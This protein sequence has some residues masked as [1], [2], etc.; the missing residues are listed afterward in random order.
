MVD[1]AQKLKI[2]NEYTRDRPYS[3]NKEI[4]KFTNIYIP[5]VILIEKGIRCNNWKDARDDFETRIPYMSLRNELGTLKRLRAVK[6]PEKLAIVGKNVFDEIAKSK[7]GYKGPIP[8]IRIELAPENEECDYDAPVCAVR[9]N[10][11]ITKSIIDGN[12]DCKTCTLNTKPI[13]AVKVG[14]DL[15]DEIIIENCGEIT[16]HYKWKRE[17]CPATKYDSILKNRLI[18]RFY[19]DTRIGTL[20]PGQI[21]RLQI[22]F[23][24][25]VIGLYREPW[26]LQVEIL[27]RL[28]PIFQINIQLQGCAISN[29]DNKAIAMKVCLLFTT[30]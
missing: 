10:D 14:E 19:F 16:I 30:M 24:P 17:E 8:S 18:G 12:S 15:W 25:N 6:S 28:D 4:Q 26:L 5:D 21:E 9:I 2:N 20:G 23:R 7:R 3:M 27:G 13:N 22:L 1:Q 11:L 29:V